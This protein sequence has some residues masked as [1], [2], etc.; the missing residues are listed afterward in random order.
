MPVAMLGHTAPPCRSD[1]VG[2]RT[3]SITY[4]LGMFTPPCSSAVTLGDEVN[5]NVDLVTVLLREKANR[6]R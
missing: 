4:A 3:C 2:M 5:T 6:A 1:A